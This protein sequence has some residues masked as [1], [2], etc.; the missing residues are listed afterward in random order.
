MTTQQA[1]GRTYDFGL[2]DRLRAAREHAGFTVR[3]FE[4]ATG[5]SRSSIGNYEAGRTIPR[6]PALVAWS[7]ATGFDLHWLETGQAPAQPQGPDGGNE[8]A[9]SEGLEPPTCWF[10]NTRHLTGAAA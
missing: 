3:D 4:V 6:R 7:M 1:A 5:I 9:R 10:E 8:L 2:S